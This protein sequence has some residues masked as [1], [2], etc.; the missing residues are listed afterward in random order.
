M[1][2]EIVCIKIE[3]RKLFK[4]FTNNKL[5]N[6]MKM[7]FKT[8]RAMRQLSTLIKKHP[9]IDDRKLELF[10]S[11]IESL[12]RFFHNKNINPSGWLYSSR[13]QEP[14][15]ECSKCDIEKWVQ[16]DDL[17][18]MD[19]N[20]FAPF[21]I[22]A[23]DIEC[24]SGDGSFPQPWRK[25]DKVIQIGITTHKLGE[26]EPYDYAMITL[27]ECDD[28]DER[29][30]VKNGK[31]IKC[32]DERELLIAFQTYFRSLDPDIVTGYNIWGFDWK[33]IVERAEFLSNKKVA[34]D[35]ITFHGEEFL[36]L[37]RIGY[38]TS[39]YVKKKLSSKAMGDNFLYYVD[40]TGVVQIDLLNTI[41]NDY[42][43]GSYKLDKVSSNFLRGKIKN[44]E[45]NIIKTDNTDGIFVNNQNIICRPI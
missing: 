7:S 40:I 39:R 5:F 35:K 13:L 1:A 3:K 43:L 12:I 18:V 24:N 34:S 28:L 14:K 19:K 2:E 33:F 26:E 42:N 38:E 4:Y 15:Y 32:K 31:L 45:K 8:K 20:S 27:G 29:T 21:R 36:K 30:T 11:N 10:E 22:A 44:M 9:I 23:F 17:E 25:S 6:F 16:Y 37:G 41:R